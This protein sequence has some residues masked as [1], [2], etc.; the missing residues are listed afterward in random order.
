M[1]DITKL[2]SERMPKLSILKGPVYSLPILYYINNLTIPGDIRSCHTTHVNRYAL[3][4]I[5]RS[6]SQLRGMGF[7]TFQEIVHPEDL[8]ALKLSLKT[9]YPAGLV[10]TFATMMRLRPYG[11]TAYRSFKC[12]KNVVETFS[13]GMVKKMMVAAF[14]VTHLPLP[15]QI[16]VPT[17]EELLQLKNGR[18][19]STLSARERDV[20]LLIVKGMDSD[21]IAGKL[22]IGIETIRKHRSSMI[23]KAGVKNTTALIAMALKN[24]GF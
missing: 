3:D 12:S 13:N 16:N 9:V 22:K 2:Y 1:K 17:A 5:C 19:F 21:E 6:Q 15:G 23:R 14:D 11:Q 18:I 24:W 7:Q 4:F 8:A 20:L 10:T